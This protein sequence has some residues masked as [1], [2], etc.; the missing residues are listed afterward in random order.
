MS[1]NEMKNIFC[2]KV[3]ELRL[4]ENIS[5]EELS[6]RSGV[7]PEMLEALERGELPEEMMVEDAFNLARTFGCEVYELFR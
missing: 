4:H 1:I 3:S 2:G 5:L 6:R 7:P